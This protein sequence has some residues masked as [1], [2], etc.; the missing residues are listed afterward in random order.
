MNLFNNK[1]AKRLQEEL[2]NQENLIKYLKSRNDFLE[3][4]YKNISHSSEM[5]YEDNQKLIQWIKKIIE[6][7]D[8]FEVSDRNPVRLPIYKIPSARYYENVNEVER[9]S[10]ETIVIP[11]IIITK[12]KIGDKQ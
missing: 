10:Q 3:K 9:I 1:K 2:K 7:F 12:N 8:V 6:A 4:M 5:I 11:E